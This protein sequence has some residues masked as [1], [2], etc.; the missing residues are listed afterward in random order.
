[1]GVDF[2]TPTRN[3]YVY[4]MRSVISTT[5]AIIWGGASQHNGHCNAFHISFHKLGSGGPEAPQDEASFVLG[6]GGR[7]HRACIPTLQTYFRVCVLDLVC[8]AGFAPGIKKGTRT[9]KPL[10]KGPPVPPPTPYGN[11]IRREV[12]GVKEDLKYKV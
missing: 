5:L 3:S 4:L 9:Q 12:R 8:S 2:G 10:P 6:R 11:K 7:K 1:M